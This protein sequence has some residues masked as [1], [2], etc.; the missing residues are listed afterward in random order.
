MGRE[1]PLFHSTHDELTG[2]YNR[3]FF[4]TEFTRLSKK[5]VI[6]NQ[7]YHSSY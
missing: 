1:N 4:D 3:L 2:L 7:R 5:P 6:P